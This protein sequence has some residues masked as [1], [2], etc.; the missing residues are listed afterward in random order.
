MPTVESPAFAKRPPLSEPS[1]MPV[2]TQM[3]S[4]AMTDPRRSS[5]ARHW[6]KALIG[7]KMS[8]LEMPSAIISARVPLKGGA[9]QP[10][11]RR[12]RATPAAPNGTN[13]YSTRERE[14]RPTTIA[15]SPMPTEIKAEGTV[16]SASER[17]STALA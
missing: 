14:S 15:P 12:N 6:T 4:R 5:G 1:R 2:K 11:I 16:A 10:R 9:D 7:M 13:P 3:F 17:P 8:A